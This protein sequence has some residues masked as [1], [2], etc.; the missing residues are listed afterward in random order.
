M[1]C[2]TPAL[3]EMP[4]L[5]LLKKVDIENGA[6]PEVIAAHNRVFVVYLDTASPQS[7]QFSV[8]VFAEDMNTEFAYKTLVSKSEYGNPTDIRVAADGNYVYAFYETADM[9]AKKS[10]LFG[11]KYNLSDGFERVAYA[12]LIAT[13]RSYGSHEPNDEHLDD[14][15][16]LIGQS[17][18]FVMTRIM[19]SSVY[20]YIAREF[21]KDLNFKKS[22]AVE[23]SSIA[24]GKG[25]Y[26]QASAVY[27]NGYYFMVIP[28]MK[29]AASLD[30]FLLKFDMN[31]Q[32]VN[33][34]FISQSPKDEYFVTGMQVDGDCFYIVYKEGEISDASSILKIFDNEF[35]E[36]ISETVKKVEVKG[37][38]LRPSL[39]VNNEKIYIGLPTGGGPPPPA[40]ASRTFGTG[41][42]ETRK[43]S[44][45][46]FEKK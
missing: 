7:S 13:S 4:T 27:Y 39:S 28:S 42:G 19:S 46:I 32:I 25:D 36:I 3:P 8:K 9:S 20:N 35:N 26:G 14:P 23:L 21:D 5:S 37:E 11:A 22:F 34:R 41:A 29:G 15:V 31:W 33:Y 17:S 6:R 40:S 30:L 12:G 16:V 38:S 18:V 24:E 1:A 43:A 10:Y 44:I 45:Y 2:R